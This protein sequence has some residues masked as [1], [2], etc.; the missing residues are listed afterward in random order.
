MPGRLLFHTHLI[1][2]GRR[3]VALRSAQKFFY[4]ERS[5]APAHRPGESLPVCGV[6]SVRTLEAYVMAITDSDRFH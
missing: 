1:L 3:A 2:A 6:H 4:P 5:L